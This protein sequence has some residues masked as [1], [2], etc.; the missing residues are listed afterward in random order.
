MQKALQVRAFFKAHFTS[1]PKDIELTDDDWPEHL[2]D[3][4]NQMPAGT[5]VIADYGVNFDDDRLDKV[6]A[7]MLE[8]T[9]VSIT[10]AGDMLMLYYGDCGIEIRHTEPLTKEG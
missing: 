6:D 8:R 5:K 3:I 2:Q 10:E 4:N 7:V 9:S 1:V